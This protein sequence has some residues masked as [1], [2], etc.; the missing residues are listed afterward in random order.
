MPR[1]PANSS[2]NRQSSKAP[3]GGARNP[4][5]SSQKATASTVSQRLQRQAAA[6]RMLSEQA[7]HGNKAISTTKR[8][9]S[10]SAEAPSVKRR[11]RNATRDENTDP[12]P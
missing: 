12:H 5:G 3:K 2:T 7:A 11:K 6:R 9:V 10:P 1:P 4:H 8:P